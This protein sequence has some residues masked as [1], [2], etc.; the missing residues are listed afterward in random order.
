MSDIHRG[1]HAITTEP[2]NTPILTRFVRFFLAVAFLPPVVYFLVLYLT[3]AT[4]PLSPTITAGLAAVLALN[5]LTAL[6]ALF[7]VIEKSPPAPSQE[8]D[9]SST[10]EPST[11]ERPK[12]E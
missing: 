10:T 6:F 7:A 1:L 12:E 2:A 4:F 5:A 3:P 8:E 9:E 11:S